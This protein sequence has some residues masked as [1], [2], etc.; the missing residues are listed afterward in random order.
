M[1]I[2]KEV[3]AMAGAIKLKPIGVA[4]SSVREHRYGGWGSNVAR[5]VLN[6]KYAKALDGIEGYSHALVLFWMH[7]VKK[8]TLKH[9]PQGTGPLVGIFACRCT[10]R[11][12]PIGITTVKILKRRGNILT[13]KGLDVLNNTPIIDIKPFTPQYDSVSSA[14]VPAWTKK[15]KY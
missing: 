1:E 7:R 13:V 12:N 6:K 2:E 4:K 8:V 3:V 14:R 11:P 15:L 5:I 10:G 9:H